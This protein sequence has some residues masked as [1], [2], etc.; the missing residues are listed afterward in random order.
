MP[1]SA[2]T[3]ISV[4]AAAAALGACAQ[5]LPQREGVLDP[6]SP[7]RIVEGRL[8][9]EE[10]CTSCHGIGPQDISPNDM[11]PPLR[12]L[13]QRYRMRE[14]DAAFTRGLLENHPAM[15]QF[16]FTPQELDALI[17]YIQSAQE[18]QGV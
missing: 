12:T 14:L 16:A 15:P 13:A 3:W 4:C 18:A 5:G 7:S 1:I 17:A 2:S 8:L 9:A 10:Y 11:A 6:P